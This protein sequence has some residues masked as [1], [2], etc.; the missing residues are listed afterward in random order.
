MYV[1]TTY[2]WKCHPQNYSV[3]KVGHHAVDRID[4]HSKNVCFTAMRTWD[5]ANTLVMAQLF[6]GEGL[7]CYV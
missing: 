3:I 7:Y 6:Y 5:F 1:K 2:G 4:L